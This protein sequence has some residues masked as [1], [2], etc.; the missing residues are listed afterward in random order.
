MQTIE[1]TAFILFNMH[2]II[3]EK[4]MKTE[5]IDFIEIQNKKNMEKFISQILKRLLKRLACIFLANEL[6]SVF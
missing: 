2:V 1:N 6:P 3:S 5:H 4:N